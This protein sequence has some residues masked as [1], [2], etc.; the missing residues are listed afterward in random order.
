[1]VKVW[2]TCRYFAGRRIVF[3]CFLSLAGKWVASSETKTSANKRDC[4]DTG[5]ESRLFREAMIDSWSAKGLSK[6]D[7]PNKNECEDKME[8]R[9]T[10][11]REN[12]VDPREKEE[13]AGKID[14]EESTSLEK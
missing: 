4:P 12:W 8:W 14:R 11:E 10:D 6:V 5:K 3:S 1:M 13:M 7:E 9:E 2:M